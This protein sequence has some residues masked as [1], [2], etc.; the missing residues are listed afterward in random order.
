MKTF[1]TNVF[2]TVVGI[3]V[4]GFVMFAF[5]IGSLLLMII[6]GSYEEG[7]KDNSVLTINLTGQMTDREEIDNPLN[8]ILGNNII[9]PVA[10]NTFVEG[11]N[12]AKENDKIKGVYLEAGMFQADSYATLQ[13]AR[14]ALVD[15]QKESG[16]WVIAYA[17][18]YT[19]QSYYLASAATKVY[20]NPQG[21]IDWHGV[22]AQPFFIKDMLAKFGVKMQV[23]KVGKY[24]S[25][26]EMFTEDKM[27]DANREQTKAYI[28]GLW[29]NVVKEVAQSRKLTEAQLNQY[30]DSAITFANPTDYQRMKLVD[31]L[32]YTDQIKQLVKSKLDVEEDDELHQVSLDDLLATDT[33][34][35][36]EGEEI[37][38]YYMAG[39]IVDGTAN[40]PMARGSVIDA[41]Q[42]CKDL[43]KLAADDNIKA[44]VLRVNSGGGSAY[45]SEQ[46]W[47]QVMELKKKKPVV[48]S[49]GGMAASGAYYLSAPANWIVA[50][51]TTLTGSIGIFGMF[52]DA[53]GL[54]TEKLGVKFDE[55]STNKHAAF[56]TI[57][58]PFNADELRILEQYIS[59]GYALFRHR[60]AEGRKMTD[61]QVEKL[62]QG[63][64]YTGEYAK[65]IG[66]VDELGDLDVAIA[67]AAKLAK[68]SDYYAYEYPAPLEWID[69]L[70]GNDIVGNYLDEKVKAQLGDLY[71]PYAL[72]KNMNMRSAIQARIPF[73][74]NIH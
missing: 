48:V 16:K 20:L 58:R 19:Q 10:L 3:F 13:E 6:G 66:L 74:P 56:G 62:A 4:A 2:S 53:S 30:A 11:L 65:T 35:T 39:D 9:T 34:I 40:N 7:I 14:K 33:D 24:K 8:K 68:L 23:A 49:M 51:P 26:T 54:L 44:V 27:S 32:L 37:A 42:V 55:V 28:T 15:F 71:Q 43:A 45:A 47:H 59:R 64:V 29:N 72:L 52:P 50:D 22:A 31:G 36:S 46:I 38:V 67:K 61:A 60:V 70:L 63:H 5:F 41:Q 21:M 17:D 73:E 18:S 12:A 69:Q 25:A 1:F 57:A